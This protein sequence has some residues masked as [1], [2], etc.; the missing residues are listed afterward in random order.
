MKMT[1]NLQ[2]SRDTLFLVDRYQGIER[3]CYL[4]LQSERIKM[5]TVGISDIFVPIYETTISHMP[6]CTNL[7]L[8]FYVGNKSVN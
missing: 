2:S 6:Q 8:I 1:I 3:T 7:H 4:N 5:G